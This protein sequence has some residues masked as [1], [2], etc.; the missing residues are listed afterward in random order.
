MKQDS[1]LMHLREHVAQ[2]GKL[3]NET[4]GLGYIDLYLMH[5]PVALEYIK[6]SE[7][8]Y[9]VIIF[10]QV[11]R[12]ITHKLQA[13]WMD[14]AHETVAVAKVP[15]METWQAMEKLVDERL[16]RSIGVSNFD[17]QL[18][19]DVLSYARHPISSLQIEHHPYLVQ[20]QLI[21]MAQEEGIAVTGYSTF[22][23]QSFLEL[24]EAFRKRAADVP[25]LFDT[26]VVKKLVTKYSRSPGQVLLRW[27]TQR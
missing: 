27:A 8:Q 12:A 26:E 2:M 21:A 19:Y 22:G 4:W 1:M 5:F 25:L 13:W 11:V 16:V 7:L 18:L 15:I 17:T 9:P 14:A 3:Q 6:P 24:P 20:P 23:P 10:K